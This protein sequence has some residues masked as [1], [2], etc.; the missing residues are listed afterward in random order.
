MNGFGEGGDDW[1]I[2]FDQIRK[3]YDAYKK[4]IQTI[5]DYYKEEYQYLDTEL[6]FTD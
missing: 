6:D 4:E 1:E 5:F 3:A 2:G